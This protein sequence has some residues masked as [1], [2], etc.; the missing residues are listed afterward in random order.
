MQSLDFRRI[1]TAIVVAGLFA[2]GQA[3]AQTP[4]A[5]VVELDTLQVS[6]ASRASREAALASRSVETLSGDALRAL[7][8]S[9]VNE[10]LELALGIDLMA[11][12]PA[13]ADVG[14]R[15]SSFEQ[16]LV[17]VDGIRVNDAQT[18]HF[19]LN[20][21]VPLDQ[22]ERVEI[23]RGSGSALHGADA[24]GGVINI[25]TAGERQ[26]T[27]ARADVG[28]FATRGIAARHALGA[29]GSRLAIAGEL[30][31]SD[32]HRAGTDYETGFLRASGSTRLSGH[33]L[34]AD[35]G[36]ARRDFGANG[37]Y[38][39]FDSYEETRTTTATFGWSA[40]SASSVAF[41]ARLSARTNDDHFVLRRTD[42]SFY[43]NRH[44]TSQLGGELTARA[45]VAP[46]MVVAGVVEG[47]G[48]ALSSESLGDRTETRWAAGMEMAGGVSGRLLGTVG[49]RADLHET[50]EVQASPSASIAWWPMPGVR[51]RGSAGRSFR[52]PSWTDR[53]YRDPVNVGNP[54]LVPERAWSTEIGGR[55]ELTPRL[56]VAAAAFERRA[57][58][59][60]D[61]SRPDDDP[62]APWTTRNVEEARFRGVELE[63]GLR[64]WIGARWTARAALLSVSSSA[65]EGF[66]SKYAL[67]PLTETVSLS[68]ERPLA[69]DFR[70]GAQARHAR[71]RGEE[72]YVLLDARASYGVRGARVHVDVRNLLDSGYADIAGQDAPGRS[73]GIGLSWAPTD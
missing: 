9:S 72:P 52:T 10:A 23:L 14:I 53:F 5:P 27:S 20:L 66:T 55:V 1:R 65:E 31:G 67:R 29:G 43:E 6:V 15:G 7:P 60:I 4:D 34:Q 37:F 32:G 48:D 30:R 56:F 21:T 22:V 68:V 35:V 41:G 18:G 64:E 28:S 39:P 63:A 17:L 58:D 38:G 25:V 8:V 70:V 12:S 71:R 54:D 13:L 11:R 42:P 57:D 49:L 3:A 19:S 50:H 61:W 69:D 33:R 46:H 73:V 40:P 44:S 36:L 2:A 24:M 47:Y 62:N 51:L 45:R 16:V 26:G 59:L